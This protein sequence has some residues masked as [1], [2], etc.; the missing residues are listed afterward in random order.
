MTFSRTII[1]LI[2]S[3]VICILFIQSC[4]IREYRDYHADPVVGGDQTFLTEGI[5]KK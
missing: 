3:C 5:I 2:L 4:D 1:P